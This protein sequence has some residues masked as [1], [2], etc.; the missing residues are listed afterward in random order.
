MLSDKLFTFTLLLFHHFP[1]C[2]C[3]KWKVF[4]L[5]LVDIQPLLSFRESWWFAFLKWLLVGSRQ[6]FRFPVYSS[7]CQVFVIGKNT[8]FLLES[9]TSVINEYFA[10]AYP[11]W[12]H[13]YSRLRHNPLAFL[14]KVSIYLSIFLDYRTQTNSRES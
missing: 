6:F 5:V 2:W 14:I 13:I 8:I 4:Y 12:Y 9:Q 3:W 7:F 10:Q 11:W 1:L